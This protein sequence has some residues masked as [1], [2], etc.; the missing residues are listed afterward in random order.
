MV[1]KFIG[2]YGVKQRASR[3]CTLGTT[4][5][6]TALKK[7]DA[8]QFFQTLLTLLRRRIGNYHRVTQPVQTR[9]SK[10]LKNV[11]QSQFN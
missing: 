8:H 5:N 10:I 4:I 6:E 11:E 1:P 2:T 3:S 7:F 9:M